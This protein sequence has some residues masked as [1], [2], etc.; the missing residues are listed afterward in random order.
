MNA[1]RAQ[2]MAAGYFLGFVFVAFCVFAWLRGA[3]RLLI[4]VLLIALLG[5]GLARFVRKV[6][7]PVD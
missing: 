2:R 7:E 3:G 6:R 4:P 5:Y 1:V